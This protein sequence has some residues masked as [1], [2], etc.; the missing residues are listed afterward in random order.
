MMFPKYPTARAVCLAL[1]GAFLLPSLLFRGSVATADE[2]PQWRGPNRDG[3]SGEKGLLQSWPKEGLE[4]E[5]L[6]R[7]AGLGYAGFAIVDSRLF[8]MGARGGREELIAVD[9]DMGKEIW[10]APMGDVLSNNWG[11]G[12]RGTPTVDSGFVYAL[13]ATG[14]LVAVKASDGEVVWSTT[15]ESLGGVTP[16]WGYSE[17][18][19]VDGQRV[20]C[21]PGGKNG[22]IAAFDKRKGKLLWQTEEFDDPAQYSSMVAAT[23]HGKKQYVQLTM[24]HVVGIKAETGEVLWKT[25]WPGKTAVIPTPIVRGNAVYI[26]S[27]YGVGCNLFRI[28]KD[29]KVTP[30]YENKT[31]KVMKNHHGGVILLEDHLYGYSDGVGWAC[32]ELE[33]GRRVWNEKKK[34]GKGAIAYADGRFYCLSESGG[35]VVLIKASPKGW[36]EQGRFRLEPQTEQRKSAGRIWTHPVIADGHLYLRDQELLF[37]FDVRKKPAQN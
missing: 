29:W 8:T 20:V 37:R 12:P 22:C 18:V 26:T 34:L 3:V 1:A 30:E 27:G 33:S 15:M 24:K 9:V 36:E 21:T 16:F 13:G 23:L 19:L 28:G 17:S 35:E 5:W 2:W 31:L 25:E 32:Q 7:D 6:F 10:K 14:T 11:D 4:P